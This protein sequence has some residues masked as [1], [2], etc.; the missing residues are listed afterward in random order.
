[1]PASMSGALRVVVPAL[2]LV[3]PVAVARAQD[4]PLWKEAFPTKIEGYD[5]SPIGS[6]VVQ[7]KAGLLALDAAT[8]KHLW[9]RPEVTKHVPIGGT[10][11]CVAETAAGSSI[12]DLETG[13]DRWKLSSL[14]LTA[15]KGTIPLP[16]RGFVLVYGEAAGSRH[17]LVAARYESGDV[18]W[19]QAELYTAP[20]FASKVHKI[21]YGRSLLDTDT[22][23]VLDPTEDGLIRLDLATGKLLWR[24]GKTELDG[25]DNFDGFT[26]AEGR[27][28]AVYGRKLLAVDGNE[29][30]VVWAMKEKL[31]TPVVQLA[32]TPH[33]LVI[34]GA[35]NVD[36]N[37]RHSWR[38]YLMLLDPATGT[39]K[40]TTENT[41]FKGRSAFVREEDRLTIALK[42]GLATYEL[43]SGKVLESFT[44][45]E[46]QGGEDP[47]CL[48]R[49]KDGGWLISSS[50]NLRAVDAGGK[51]IYSLYLK[52]PGASFMAK[53]AST[54]LQLAAGVASY[55]AAGPG[56]TYFVPGNRTLTARF[57]AT[58]D[59]EHLTYVFT[60][61][62]NP[63]AKPTKFRLARIDKETGKEVARLHFTDR[64]PSYRLDPATGLV[65]VFD[66]GALFGMRFPAPS[67]GTEF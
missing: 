62:D 19:K 7:F 46:F 23:V 16:S 31:R 66:D 24:L 60:E 63:D 21:K 1:M 58:V 54:A 10:P 28:F 2:L 57:K 49:R 44:L 20:A 14:G 37:G 36:D 43:P 59:A 53:L 41:D 51:P 27:I 39:S 32:S 18:L 64:A 15:V 50:Q 55:A 45:P 11:F 67:A 52:A 9:S 65:V 48:E 35:Y 30:K 25:E 4:A 6:V 40:W 22:T 33:G 34:R 8:G 38:P 26:A 3:V 56:G 5:F 29:G 47:C 61:D 12:I 17:T 42:K 13:Q